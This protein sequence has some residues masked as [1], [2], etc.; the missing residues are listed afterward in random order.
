MN[1][2]PSH[3]P[4]PRAFES[5]FPVLDLSDDFDR[6]EE[7]GRNMVEFAHRHGLADLK[8]LEHLSRTVCNCSYI[9]TVFPRAGEEDQ[10]LASDIFIWFAAFDDVHVERLDSTAA[11]SLTRHVFA[12]LDVL[13]GNATDPA[14]G[15]STALA[16]ILRRAEK[17]DTRQQDGLRHALYG[18]LLGWQWEVQL[19]NARKQPGIQTYMAVRRHSVAG[20]LERAVAEPLSGHVLPGAA[21]RNSQFVRLNRAF[22]N[23]SG[24]LN[25]LCS[26][27]KER[28]QD[29]DSA[30]NLPN[31]LTSEKGCS[32]GDA[33]MRVS[34]LIVQEAK[35]AAEMIRH[36][37]ESPLPE[38]RAYAHDTERRLRAQTAFYAAARSRYADG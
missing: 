5:C 15:F 23:I 28:R 7:L 21:R 13:G 24:W 2:T 10:Q 27:E 25:D 20:V 30:V 11:D 9:V 34:E 36:L 29:G 18:A 4:I 22:D 37:A 26:Y 16:E 14:P 38:V 3:E 12:L 1:A 6:A 31:V 19:R 8:A 32:L 33:L 17:W 35:V